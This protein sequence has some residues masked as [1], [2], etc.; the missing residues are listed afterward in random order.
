M[1]QSLDHEHVRVELDLPR[2]V[3]VKLSD[4]V[5]LPPRWTGE[6]NQLNS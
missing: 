6:P 5:A 1:P 4:F 2:L 3:D